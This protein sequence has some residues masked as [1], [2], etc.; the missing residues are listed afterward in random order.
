MGLARDAMN[1]IEAILAA[2]RE[3][4]PPKG[5]RA[6]TVHRRVWEQAVGP[7]IGN[8]TEPVKLERG[9]LL[10]RVAT[11]A[12]ASE[13]SLLAEGIVAALRTRK[14]DVSSIRFI[15]GRLSTDA[16]TSHKPANV[17]PQPDAELPGAIAALV[18]R[19]DSPEL[20][21]ALARAAAWSLAAARSEPPKSPPPPHPA[22]AQAEPD[23]APESPVPPPA[24]YAAFE[25]VPERLRRPPRAPGGSA[26][27]KQLQPEP[28]SWT[29]RAPE[30]V[31]APC[32][33]QAPATRKSARGTAPAAR[34]EAVTRPRRR[35][36]R[37]SS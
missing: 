24:R 8:R 10:V 9:V 30:S 4:R 19:I 12:W 11:S 20:R 3:L 7:R 26:P 2:T 14:V 35:S 31:V 36:N 29:D 28:T 1:K 18:E 25:H 15:V 13:L 21:E 23:R 22:R 6:L 37:S 32:P 34:N 33:P 5:F 17:P 16:A 27:K